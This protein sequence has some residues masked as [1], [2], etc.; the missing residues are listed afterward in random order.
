LIVQVEDILSFLKGSMFHV[1]LFSP[2]SSI[3]LPTS[4]HTGHGIILLW[5]SV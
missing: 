1:P 5:C 3:V 2:G 4:C